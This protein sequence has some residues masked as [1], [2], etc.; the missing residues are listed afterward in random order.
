M[1]KRS[2]LLSIVLLMTAVLMMTMSAQATVKTVK[3]TGYARLTSINKKNATTLKTGKTTLKISKCGFLKF[4]PPYSGFYTFTFVNLTETYGDNNTGSAIF[5]D[6]K[7]ND[8]TFVTTGGKAATAYFSTK[9]GADTRKSKGSF[10]AK[11]SCT[12]DIVKA[13]P[14]YIFVDVF[15][16]GT[17]DITIRNHP[18][19]ISKESISLK[20]GKTFKLAV[21]NAPGKVK[22][23]SSDNTV[24]K[25]YTS[26]KVKAFGAGTAVITAKVGKK[27]ATCKVTVKG[28]NK[29]TDNSSGSSDS[30]SG[31]SDSGSSS[32]GS[33][34]SS[35][36]SDGSSDSGSSG[37]GMVW[38]PRTG[39][40]YHSHSGCSGMRSPSLVSLSDAIA[41]GYTAC[42]RCW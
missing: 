42:S 8:L 19:T 18:M 28:T 38:I 31:S 22:W 24:A 27:K 17:L 20:E 41:W 6:G 1:M 37:A 16:K 33:G 32:G 11:R 21:K 9:K 26:G 40:K 10:L 36:S 25:V 39:S 14:I 13:K 15:S 7:E 35:G 2:R 23:S 29:S 4:T 30:G 34:S 12:L 3:N 5:Y